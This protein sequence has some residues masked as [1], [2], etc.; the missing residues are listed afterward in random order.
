MPEK[1]AL[2]IDVGSEFVHLA[3]LH[4]GE[5]EEARSV[6]H[7]GNPIG[8]VKRLYGKFL[9]DG[10]RESD[11]NVGFTGGGGKSIADS[12]GAP[13][14][15]ETIAIPR[16]AVYLE[17]N[18]R[19]IFHIGAKNPYFFEVENVGLNGRDFYNTSDIG[20]GTK[21]G[22]GSGILITKQCRRFF[23]E[24]VGGSDMQGRIE[25]MY[26]RAYKMA[27]GADKEVNVG[28]RCGVVIQSDM[29]HLQNS[30]ESAQNIIRGLFETVARNYKSDVIRLREL[31]KGYGL[32]TGGVCSNKYIVNMLERHL[33]VRIKVPMYNQ[34]VGAIGAALHVFENCDYGKGRI[35]FN[36]LERALDLERASI[37]YA[38]PLSSALCNVS[39][40]SEGERF[41][42]KGNIEIYTPVSEGLEVVL[43]ID[44][45]ST[46]TKAVI[47]RCL[48]SVD[49]VA[50]ICIE[51][52]GRP[53][54]AAQKVF[55]ELKE[56][57]GSLKIKAVGYTGSS[58]AFYNRMFSDRK[59]FSEIS[60][61]VK[62]E[63]TC[64]AL[65]VKHYNGD[66][67]TIFELG[68][69]DAKF[70]VFDGGNVRKAKMNLSC[71]AG[72]GQTMQNM[73]K[74]IGLNYM[75]FDEH[76]L[77][78]KRTPVV[79]D[80]CGVFTEAD[81]VK[82]IGLGL[83]KEEIAAGIVYACIGGYVN[84]FIGSEGFGEVIS[85]QGGPFN[86]RACLAALALQTGRKINAFPHRQLFGAYGAAIAAYNN[87]KNG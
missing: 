26:D 42:R 23:E 1:Y 60:D 16:G 61:V 73:M 8:T 18:A 32:A 30:G 47:A 65:G 20:T 68:G 21:C 69:Q 31:K 36:G 39:E 45:G 87:L 48:P 29:I 84:K 28:G 35:D 5:V 62:D 15:F 44:G 2:G 25:E 10:L 24:E 58:G 49:A 82:L 81:I 27:L 57:F 7:F 46:T 22:G 63:I 9:E 50:G 51:T 53:I 54:E 37:R 76:A 80:S 56:A 12:V 79:D 85:A 6:I 78:A 66:V 74:M 71:M 52:H 41:T 75:E 83:P 17:P 55:S 34:S 43:G 72:T 70:T 59:R 77:R 13:Y 33:G 38:P 67:D 86:S 3:V 64:H 14:F 19:Y 11:F 4:D 40:N